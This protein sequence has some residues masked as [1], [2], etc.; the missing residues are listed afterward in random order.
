MSKL[1]VGFALVAIGRVEAL[2]IAQF[3]E[4]DVANQVTVR[5][6][7][8]SAVDAMLDLQWRVQAAAGG[9]ICVPGSLDVFRSTNL[10]HRLAFCTAS[11]S[12]PVAI[13]GKRLAIFKALTDG[14]GVDGVNQDGRR[15]MSPWESN[16]GPTRK[17]WDHHR[18]LRRSEARRTVTHGV[19][20][21]KSADGVVAQR[22][23]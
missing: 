12:L 20:E 9:E 22:R 7:G 10:L 18:T 17:G 11:V 3:N 14:S 23:A 21:Q 5:I 4:A 2:P 19:M 16:C 13:R 1:L 6:A 8:S 15:W